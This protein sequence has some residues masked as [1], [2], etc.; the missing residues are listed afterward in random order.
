VDAP[1]GFEANCERWELYQPKVTRQLCE[2]GWAVAFQRIGTWPRERFSGPIRPHQ[3]GELDE[4]LAER[5]YFDNHSG[6]AR[7]YS[8]ALA[9]GKGLN[10]KPFINF[11]KAASGGSE[12]VHNTPPLGDQVF[13]IHNSSRKIKVSTR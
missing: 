1:I 10:R 7:F 6:S 3:A 8:G 9:A 4:P 5:F 12:A 11:K 13:N 2:S